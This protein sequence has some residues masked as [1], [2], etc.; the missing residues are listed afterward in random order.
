MSLAATH[1]LER[2]SFT[3]PAPWFRMGPLMIINIFLTTFYVIVGTFFP[4]VRESV[5]IA[6]SPM[7]SGLDIVGLGVRRP[8]LLGQLDLIYYKN[9]IGIGVFLVLCLTCTRLPMCL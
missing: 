8:S 9:L 4:H 5:Y 6:P 3:R 7:M 2:D 1:A